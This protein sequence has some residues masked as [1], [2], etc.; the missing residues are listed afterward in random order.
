M[1]KKSVKR[2]MALLLTMTTTMTSFC[3]N[4]MEVEALETTPES[5]LEEMSIEQKVAQMMLIGLPEEPGTDVTYLSDQGRSV[6]EKY[7]FSGI[8]LFR[9]N[10]ISTDQSVAL[11]NDLQE[12]NASDPHRPALF[13]AA[14]QEGGLVWRLPVGVKFSGNMALGATGDPG[15]AMK[16]GQIV[17][18][19]MAKMGLNVDFAPVVDVNSNPFN[20]VIGTR[21]FSDDPKTV[22]S[23]AISMMQGLWSGE[24]G[25]IG[26]VLTCLKHFPGHG[27]TSV[28]SHTGLPVVM[29]TYEDL[30]K[31][32]LIPFKD[33]IDAGADMIMTAH[34]SF[35]NIDPNSY[36]SIKDGQPISLPA[37]LSERILTGILRQDMGYDGVIVTDALRMGAISEHFQPQDTARLAINAGADILLLPVTGGLTEIDN[38]IAGVKSQIENGQIDIKK[39]DAAVL[40]ILRLKQKK[41]LLN[42][43]GESGIPERIKDASS[44]VGIKAHRDLEWEIAKKSITLIKNKKHTLPLNGSKRTSI[45]VPADERWQSAQDGVN[46]MKA[47]GV[48][49]SD[50]YVSVTSY[51]NLSAEDMANRVEGAKNV[52]I[53]TSISSLSAMSPQDENGDVSPAGKVE[54]LTEE[55]SQKKGVKVVVVPYGLPYEA[56]R[57][58]KSDALMLCWNSAGIAAATYLAFLKDGNSSQD[59]VYPATMQSDG[60]ISSLDL[61]IT[62]N[63]PVQLPSIREDYSLGE[64][65][66]PRGYGL[67]YS[68]PLGKLKGSNMTAIPRIA[69]VKV[70][71]KNYAYTGQAIDPQ[72]IVKDRTGSSLMENSDYTVTFDKNVKDV[73]HYK[74]IVCF[75]GNYSG[76]MAL[77]FD[78]VPK[79]TVFKKVENDYKGFSAY[80]E[81]R[82]KQVSGYEIEYGPAKNYMENAKMITISSPQK[83]QRVVEGLK[84][85]S[86]Y[87]VRIRTFK[88]L[89][90]GSKI[91]SG[92][93]NM[94][95]VKPY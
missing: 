43:Y 50:A 56:D 22:S 70:K 38:Y 42:G 12:A 40:R 6:M 69:T 21:S 34:I 11:I 53:F 66:Y 20:P 37:S 29:K 36:I 84:S 35:P 91:V 64:I 93:S 86:I 31:N 18:S 81:K 79:K 24:N 72:I 10:M 51:A 55:L 17:G 89:N 2:M 25:E 80:W 54:A 26:G 30:Q 77:D 46:R 85:D 88:T 48:L 59:I 45:L 16:Q 87:F 71:N 63:L 95:K 82:T 74:A 67:S 19:E 47:D 75:L 32:E 73:G 83:G 92:W 60:G 1:L 90:D 76:R 8:I 62:G 68:G 7:G 3:G 52:I 15:Y 61:S 33:C 13:I 39:V 65:K 57:Y 41:G 28:D 5:M 44:Y 9:D 58:P 49:P 78:V 94:K 23:F 4:K 27:D 14:D